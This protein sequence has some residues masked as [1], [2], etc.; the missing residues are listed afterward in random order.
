[1]TEQSR[2]DKPRI[3][4]VAVKCTVQCVAASTAH[5]SYTHTHILYLR[6]LFLIKLS[7]LTRFFNYIFVCTV[8]QQITNSISYGSEPFIERTQPEYRI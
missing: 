1:M 2:V 5:L 6:N 8:Q 7:F 4:G 3:L